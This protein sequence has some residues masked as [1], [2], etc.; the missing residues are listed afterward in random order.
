M[1]MNPSFN[2]DRQDVNEDTRIHGYIQFTGQSIKT[3]R[4][5]NSSFRASTSQCGGFPPDAGS[6]CTR[7]LVLR[8]MGAVSPLYS[9]RGNNDQDQHDH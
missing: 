6:R 9:V 4:A 2:G 5:Y 7:T 8:G 1:R 3:S